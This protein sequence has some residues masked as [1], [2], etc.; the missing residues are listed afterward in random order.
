LASAKKGKSKKKIKQ[1]SSTK[2]I[3]PQPKLLYPLSNK[4]PSAENKKSIFH[5]VGVMS[6]Q[7]ETQTTPY[8]EG[9]YQKFP[10]EIIQSH[11]PQYNVVPYSRGANPRPLSASQITSFRNKSKNNTFFPKFFMNP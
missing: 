8:H 7:Q 5:A 10:K 4:K 3:L 9:V 6:T 1:N 11:I 2:T